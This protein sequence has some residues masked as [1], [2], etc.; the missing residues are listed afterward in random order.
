MDKSKLILSGKEYAPKRPTMKI[1]RAIVEHDAETKNLSITEIL[2]SRIKILSQ[3]YGIDTEIIEDGI[4][5]SDVLPAYSE[6]A[7]WVLSLVF[8]KLDKIPNAEAG[9]DET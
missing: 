1:W 2:D 3:I 6:A 4:E 8:E 9:T 7:K 5:I